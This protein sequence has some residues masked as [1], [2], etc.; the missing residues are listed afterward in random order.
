MKT[1]FFAFAGFWGLEP[2][3]F[4]AI[5]FILFAW[6]AICYLAIR[7]RVAKRKFAL[8]FSIISVLF[9]AAAL[10]EC[11]RSPGVSPILIFLLGTFPAGFIVALLVNFFKGKRSKREI[12]EDEMED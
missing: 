5:V 11:S 6:T 12:A 10:W 8:V 4:I 1:L 3:E 7:H 9:L 2:V